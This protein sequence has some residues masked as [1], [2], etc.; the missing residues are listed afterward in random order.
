MGLKD[1]LIYGFLLAISIPIGYYIKGCRDGRN[2][3]YISALVGFLMVLFVC[4]F[5][6]IHSLLVATVNAAVVTFL[7]KRYCN[8][9]VLDDI[10]V[11]FMLSFIF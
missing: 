2:K 7:N 3:Q 8:I 4:R 10:L 6:L 11:V 9:V 5:D 1:D